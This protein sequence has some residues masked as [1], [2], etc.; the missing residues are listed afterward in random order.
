V[1]VTPDNFKKYTAGTAGDRIFQEGEALMAQ[2]TIQ[3]KAAI[4]AVRDGKLEISCGYSTDLD[5]TAGKTPKGEQYDAVQR[6][7]R[8]NHIALVD[9]GRAG[10]EIKIQTDQ[11]ASETNDKEKIMSKTILVDGLQVEVTDA[12]AVAITKLLDER[13]ARTK[14]LKI[15]NDAISTK[16]AELAANK[17]TLA[18]RDKQIGELNA[19]LKDEAFIDA[20]LEAKIKAMDGFKA[21]TGKEADKSLKTSEIIAAAVKGEL[22]DTAKDYTPEQFKV[23]FDVLLKS[24]KPKDDLA[25]AIKD[26]GGN[27]DKRSILQRVWDEANG[28]K[29]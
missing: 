19:R 20:A 9:A 29:K 17:V 21:I 12:A 18:A 26:G 15:T 4:Q 7:I 13:E 24:A 14:E 6:K 25:D 23:A 5:W 27:S 28:G 8:G 22:A 2:L 3:D 16:D 1:N 11:K 10:C